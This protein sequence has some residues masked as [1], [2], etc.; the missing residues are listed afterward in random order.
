MQCLTLLFYKMS[1]IYD[2]VFFMFCEIVQR[3]N[4]WDVLVFLRELIFIGQLPHQVLNPRIMVTF[5]HDLLIDPNLCHQLGRKLPTQLV[6]A[7]F[8]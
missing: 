1:A 4:K 2:H 7:F 6:T 8:P 3:V 5:S